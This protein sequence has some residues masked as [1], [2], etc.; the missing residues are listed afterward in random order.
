MPDITKLY[1]GLDA[2][3]YLYTI[4]YALVPS[5]M[6]LRGVQVELKDYAEV[7]TISADDLEDVF[8][9]MQGECWSPRGEA[10]GLISSLG[11]RHTSMS[12]GDIVFDHYQNKH[13]AVMGCGFA[14]IQIV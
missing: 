3:A 6:D 4:Y 5:F 11:L 12:V 1:P 7:G 8:C 13:F 14:E 2:G 10:R 9:K